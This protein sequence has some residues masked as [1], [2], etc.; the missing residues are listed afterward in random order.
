M[1]SCSSKDTPVDP[2][3]YDKT[4]KSRVEAVLHDISKKAVKPLGIIKSATDVQGLFY[5]ILFIRG[6]FQYQS[7][8]RIIEPKKRSYIFRFNSW[9]CLSSFTLLIEQTTVKW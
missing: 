5:G 2:S 3:K 1:K 9:R 8:Q 6:I 7:K 4:M